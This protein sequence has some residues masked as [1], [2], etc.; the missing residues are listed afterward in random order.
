[1]KKGTSINASP[2]PDYVE[3]GGACAHRINKI[4]RAT[5]NGN[6]RVLPDK[7]GRRPPNPSL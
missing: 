6:G 2:L 4:S 3:N 1:M 7:A 5:G